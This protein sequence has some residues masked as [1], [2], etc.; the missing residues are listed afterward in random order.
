M[1]LPGYPRNDTLVRFKDNQAYI[2]E[3]KQKLGLD[4]TKRVVLY[5]PTWR[6]NQFNIKTG[7]HVLKNILDEDLFTRDFEDTI[8]LYRGHYFT[9][10]ES[11]MNNFID[12]SDY[13][14]LNDL[15]LVADV[16]ITDYSSLFF[17]FL[18]LEKQVV[19]YMPDL[20]EYA[21]Q[22]RGF[23]LDVTTELPYLIAE[24]LEELKKQLNEKIINIDKT[25][26]FNRQYNPYEDG[27]SSL[28]VIKEVGI[29]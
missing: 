6:D 12:V 25:V 15:F 10:P 22:T 27:F 14:N 29:I 1:L 24:D 4:S 21:N 2:S 5:A 3:V 9:R 19:F 11:G 13:S 20:I 8:F 18:I 26:N 23:Y 28:R 16:L 7:K 17:D